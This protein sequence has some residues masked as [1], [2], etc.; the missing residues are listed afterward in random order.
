MQAQ[1]CSAPLS[2]IVVPLSVFFRF[3]F[4]FFLSASAFDAAF[5]CSADFSLVFPLGVACVGG[6]ATGTFS[7]GVTFS[8]GFSI[9]LVWLG[10]GLAGGNAL[11]FGAGAGGGVTFSGRGFS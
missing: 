3:F 6:R 10:V 4:F 9:A 1:C 11:I 8:E 7:L 5:V 2:K